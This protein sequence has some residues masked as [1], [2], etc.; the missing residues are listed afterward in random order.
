MRKISI[1]EEQLLF[2]LFRKPIFLEVITEVKLI[3]LKNLMNEPETYQVCSVCT[4]TAD[5]SM[6]SLELKSVSS[7]RYYSNSA[8]LSKSSFNSFI[9]Y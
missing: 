7:E 6:L 5:I 9:S 8:L 4:V 1:K 3:Q 2:R